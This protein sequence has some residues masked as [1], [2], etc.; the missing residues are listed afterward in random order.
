MRVGLSTTV[1]LGDLGGYFFGNF[2]DK[3]SNMQES[4][5]PTLT[6]RQQFANNVPYATPC[7][8][9]IDCK[10]NDLE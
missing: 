8:P 9:V 4:Q 3:A 10:I 7:R 1:I 5:H 2:R 6:L